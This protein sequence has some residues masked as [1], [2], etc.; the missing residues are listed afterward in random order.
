MAMQLAIHKPAGH[1]VSLDVDC[2]EVTVSFIEFEPGNRKHLLF[3]RNTDTSPIFLALDELSLPQACVFF[4]FKP[5]LELSLI[6]SIVFGGFREHHSVRKVL[7][8]QKETFVSEHVQFLQAF[9]QIVEN[10]L[11]FQLRRVFF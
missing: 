5:R 6:I 4:V 11:V 10:F 3:G 2:G 9:R 7:I 1:Y 8:S